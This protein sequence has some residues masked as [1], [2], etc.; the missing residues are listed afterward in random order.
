[1][2]SSTADSRSRSLRARSGPAVRFNT[3]SRSAGITSSPSM[4][5]GAELA[6]RGAELDDDVVPLLAS[7]A[8]HA[9]VLQEEEQEEEDDL[10]Q[11][12]IC[13]STDDP[14]SLIAPCLCA[15]SSKYVH[16]ACLDE[17][18]AQERVPRAF[19]QCPTCKFEYNTFTVE[20]EAS[21]RRR[22]RRFSLFIARDS[23]GVFA[24]SQ[25]VI[26]L[27][28][29]LMHA[30]DASSN[31]PKFF[32]TKWASEHAAAPY[33]ASA[34]VVLLAL[35]G[36]LGLYLKLTG[37]LPQPPQRVLPRHGRGAA[38]GC[39]RCCARLGTCPADFCFY[40]SLDGS[41]CELCARCCCLC[42][43]DTSLLS[44]SC[45]DGLFNLF[46]G[47]VRRTRGS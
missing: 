2:S 15:G 39:D 45:V 26:G 1:M 46:A 16:R 5:A 27:I 23:C 12:R 42:C 28:A 22:E 30:V 14:D 19:S 8:A 24:L 47:A 11:C 36:I 4:S 18:R 20:D 44:S 32:P 6:A 29:L 13:L 37:N 41:S 21:I 43:Q 7:S 17:W 10:R 31:I 25:A 34:V 35:L 3:P 9:H 38:A 33:Y 40:C